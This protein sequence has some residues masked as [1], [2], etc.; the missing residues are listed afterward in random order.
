MTSERAAG[1]KVEVAIVALI[2]LFGM[3]LLGSFHMAVEFGVLGGRTKSWIPRLS[4]VS[5][6]AA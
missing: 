4:Q 3:C 6:K 1:G 5:S 2:K